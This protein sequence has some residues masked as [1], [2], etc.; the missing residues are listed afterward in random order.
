[1]EDRNFRR[2][3]VREDLLDVAAQAQ[4]RRGVA[5]GLEVREALV[6]RVVAGAAADDLVGVSTTVNPVSQTQ[7]AGERGG[8]LEG[9]S[10]PS[11]LRVRRV[12]G[13]GANGVI[14]QDRIVRTCR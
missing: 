11:G 1:M 2:V 3:P 14:V 5:H 9:A 4:S 10:P 13:I 7:R 8:G 6:V 12:L